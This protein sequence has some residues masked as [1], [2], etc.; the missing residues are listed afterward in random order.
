LIQGF[1]N[2]GTENPEFPFRCGLHT[3]RLVA[4]I[5]VDCLFIYPSHR[6]VHSDTTYSNSAN[7]TRSL[8]HS[9]VQHATDGI[10]VVDLDGYVI[11]S[12]PAA[13][14]LFECRHEDVHGQMFG[15][16]IVANQSTEI[17]ILRRE[18]AMAVAEMR[19]SE[20]QWEGK[21]VLI[22]MLRDISARKQIERELRQA[23]EELA[24]LYRSAPLGVIALR[25][26]W[27]VKLWNPAAENIFGWKGDEVPV[28]SSL[29]WK[30][31]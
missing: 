27:R 7:A 31:C 28:A 18:G 3:R 19:V 6:P 24:A 12:N 29:T 26:D 11:H 10:V 4:H 21:R 5:I 14:T 30:N 1:L 25:T 15:F 13:A 16:P 2:Q 8:F 17:D 20:G 23:K 22:A 9:I